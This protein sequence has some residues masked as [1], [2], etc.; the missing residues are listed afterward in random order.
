[1]LKQLEQMENNLNKVLKEQG[2]SKAWLS[3]KMGVSQP[4]IQN[5]VKSTTL[6]R[7]KVEAIAR[8]LNV[9]PEKILS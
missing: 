8:L 7:F 4:T 6:D 9:E 5:W 2:R 3:R 1:M